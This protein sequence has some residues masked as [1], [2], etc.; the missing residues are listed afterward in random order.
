MN[1]MIFRTEKIASL[2]RQED[3]ATPT[4]ASRTEV[5]RKGKALYQ[6]R[7]NMI[8]NRL[9]NHKQEVMTSKRRTATSMPS[10]ISNTA[11]LPKRNSRGALDV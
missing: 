11:V 7:A 8:R 4:A 2:P 6:Q 1:S 10:Q 3:L 5:G 9:A